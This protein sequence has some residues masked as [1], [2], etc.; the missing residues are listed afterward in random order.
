MADIQLD[1]SFEK[2][3]KS[4][5]HENLAPNLKLRDCL[6]QLGDWKI[7]YNLKDV[8]P[9]VFFVHK[10]NRGG[11]GL[12]PYNVHKNAANIITVGADRKA[13]GNALACELAPAGHPKRGEHIQFNVRLIE[14]S[15]GLLA[16]ANGEE[17][18]VSLGCGHTVGWCKTAQLAG[19]TPEAKLADADGNID[20]HK[21]DKDSE[22]NAMIHTGWD[23]EIVPWTIDVRFPRFSH[24]A[25]AA[26]NANN[27]VASLVSELETAVTLANVMRDP[28][29]Q[30]QSGGHPNEW[31]QLALNNVKAVCAPSSSYAHVI[32]NYVKQFAGGPGAPLIIFMDGVAKQFHC[33]VNLGETFWGAIT[34]L[35]FHNKLQK[36]PLPRTALLLGNLTCNKKEDGVAKVI[37]RCDLSKL[38]S[39]SQAALVQ[40]CEDA[41][42]DSFRMVN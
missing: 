41:L 19:K 4:K 42:K 1:P 38:C 25:Q 35:Q 12:N 30:I 34:E 26:L 10:A 3:F 15:Y 18:F 23:W 5:L 32:L 37:L 7:S 24:V 20:L 21:L 8:N 13:L 29:F 22:L 17:R 2:A 40:Q 6:Q 28:M 14:K 31:E 39:K 11:L 33:T 9:K 16:P 36:Y 27:H